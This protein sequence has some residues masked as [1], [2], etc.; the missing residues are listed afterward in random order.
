M[1]QSPVEK[2]ADDMGNKRG[3][4]REC[5]RHVQMEPYFK[6]GL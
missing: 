2:D 5:Q 6:H 1:L 4:E 3:N